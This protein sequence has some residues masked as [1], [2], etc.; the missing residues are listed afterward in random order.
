MHVQSALKPQDG[1]HLTQ[2]EVFNWNWVLIDPEL[3]KGGRVFRQKVKYERGMQLRNV[4]AWQQIAQAL[5]SGLRSPVME[6]VQGNTKETPVPG[7]KCGDML[8]FDLDFCVE[9]HDPKSEEH[10]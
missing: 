3:R 5:S 1:M 9:K 7:N 2:L 8:I 6:E 10:I 4:C